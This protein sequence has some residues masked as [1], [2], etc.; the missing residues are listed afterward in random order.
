[1]EIAAY[2]GLSR[3]KLVWVEAKDGAVYQ[4][5]QLADYAREV[6]HPVFGEPDAGRVLTIIP[7]GM[8]ALVDPTPGDDRWKTKTWADVALTSERLGR[9]WG[10][11]SGRHWRHD[12]MKPQAPSQWRYLAELV[13]QLE[14]KEY[15]RMQPLTP[16]DVI[17]AQ[18][19]LS[20]SKHRRS[21]GQGRCSGHRRRDENQAPR[22]TPRALPDIRAHR[23]EV[24]QRYEELRTAYPE[25]LYY[26]DE[27]WTPNRLGAPAFCAGITFDGLSEATRYALTDETWQASLPKGVTVGGRGKFLRVVRTKYLSEL[28][29]AGATFDE[30]ARELGLWA[31]AAITDLMDK[32]SAPTRQLEASAPVNDED[33]SAR[34]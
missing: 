1:M 13:R 2:D 26:H 16:E 20:L 23:R 19:H 14:E 6:R 33:E 15:A 11:D 32:V 21:A 5:D 7:P 9:E 18:R 4:P 3:T 34:A 29:V 27:D 8:S 22:H 25:L 17:A 12:A 24:V 28:I 10:R 31:N 30:Q